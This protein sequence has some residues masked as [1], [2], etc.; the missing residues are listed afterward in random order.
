LPPLP[1]T[2]P[3]HRAGRAR[4]AL[5]PEVPEVTEGEPCG[6][7]SIFLKNFRLLATGFK[8]WRLHLSSK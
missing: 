3:A 7:R 1:D 8:T 4:N 5:L 6:N 2:D